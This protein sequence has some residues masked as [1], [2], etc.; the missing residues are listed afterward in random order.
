M[1]YEEAIKVLENSKKFYVTEAKEAFDLAIEALQKQ[2][3]MKP[4][5]VKELV[6]WKYKC[7]VCGA[8]FK[9]FAR[10]ICECGQ[11]IDWS[12]VEK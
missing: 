5:E 6:I 2:V 12:E 1:T 8:Y 3:P 11:R 10:N 9:T 4:V 7:P